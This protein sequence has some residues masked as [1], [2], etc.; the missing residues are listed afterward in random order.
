M[1]RFM[2]GKREERERERERERVHNYRCELTLVH[3]I[4]PVVNIVAWPRVANFSITPVPIVMV[5]NSINRC[6]EDQVCR[7]HAGE[8]IHY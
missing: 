8:D 2:K 3:V 4:V 5:S 1:T 7:D 6:I